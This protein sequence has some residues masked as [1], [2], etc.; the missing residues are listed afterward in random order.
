MVHQ[1]VEVK[2]FREPFD[3]LS[4]FSPHSNRGQTQIEAT[5]RIFVWL[6]P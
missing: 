2:E 5:D 6:R 1:T 4:Y 3:Y